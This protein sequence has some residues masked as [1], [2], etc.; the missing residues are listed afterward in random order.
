MLQGPGFSSAGQI[1]FLGRF[2]DNSASKS[3]ELIELV[4]AKSLTSSSS[5]SPLV[6][7][8]YQSNSNAVNTF[9]EE[10]YIS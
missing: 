9:L 8:Y 10:N 7:E 4:T 6:D 1:F 3:P 5:A 2:G